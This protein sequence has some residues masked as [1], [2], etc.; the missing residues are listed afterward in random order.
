MFSTNKP[1]PA[2]RL[3]HRVGRDRDDARFAE[4][5]R[6]P[7]CRSSCSR[8][9]PTWREVQRGSRLS[10]KPSTSITR[11]GD[12]MLCHVSKTRARRMLS[13]QPTTPRRRLSSTS[14]SLRPTSN[15]GHTCGCG[16]ESSASRLPMSARLHVA[17]G[18]DAQPGSRSAPPRH[19]ATFVLATA[20]TR[21]GVDIGARFGAQ[22]TNSRRSR[23]TA[24][25]VTPM[26]H[27]VAWQASSSRTVVGAAGSAPSAAAPFRSPRP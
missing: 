21:A 8:R 25:S 7:R 11:Y 19:H 18:D 26:T 20:V 27:R 13:G 4:L 17:D 14:K 10:A 23:S 24:R 2:G 16:V 12:R 9:V 6:D 5:R 1:R 15:A 3:I 22:L